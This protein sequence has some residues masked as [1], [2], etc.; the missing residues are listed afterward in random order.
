MPIKGFKLDSIVADG[1]GGPESGAISM[2]YAIAL[3]ETGQDH[4]SIIVNQIGDTVDEL[5]L[6]SPGKKLHINIRYQPV[7]DFKNKPAQEKNI[8]RLEVI[9][10]AMLRIQVEYNE[11]DRSKL[12][13]IKQ[14][15][16]EKNF[17]FEYFIK[18]FSH[19][20]NKKL[21]AYISVNPKMHSFDYSLVTTLDGIQTSKIPF[22][23]GLTNTYYLPMFFQK[24]KWRGEDRIV[25]TG[26]G[27]IVETHVVLADKVVSY[28]NL[29]KYEKPPLFELMKAGISKQVKEKHSLNWRDSLDP[30][31]AEILDQIDNLP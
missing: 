1:V 30:K 31:V 25:L 21:V 20:K 3:H 9:H 4:Y 5:I 28:V 10:Q 14:S 12:E 26:K 22:Y 8:F 13:A 19:P 17:N 24:A 16:L 15:I 18:K 27:N 23:K 6:K 7:I 29:T 2:I 11:Y